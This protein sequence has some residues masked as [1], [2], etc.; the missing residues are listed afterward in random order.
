LAHSSCNGA[1]GCKEPTP[2]EITKAKAIY[3]ILGLTP[4]VP[5]YEWVRWPRFYSEEEML[6]TDICGAAKRQWD[7]FTPPTLAAVWPAQQ[8]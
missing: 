6:K 3:M 8:E 4:F 7:S 1:R 2:E 5:Q